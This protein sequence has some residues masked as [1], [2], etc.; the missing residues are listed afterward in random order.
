[1]KQLQ[2]TDYIQ[3][4]SVNFKVQPSNTGAAYFGKI[5]HPSNSG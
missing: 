5:I 2:H 1:M 3:H 4:S